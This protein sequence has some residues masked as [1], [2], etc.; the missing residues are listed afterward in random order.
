[1]EALNASGTLEMRCWLGAVWTPPWL[2]LGSLGEVNSGELCQ[3]RG[4][5]R[6]SQCPPEDVEDGG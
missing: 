5:L 3:A 6:Y 4:W 2:R 1:M